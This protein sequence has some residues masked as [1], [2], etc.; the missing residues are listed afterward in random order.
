MLSGSFM[1]YQL[2]HAAELPDLDI[3][4]MS[5]PTRAN[6]QGVKGACQAR[7]IAA[8]QTIISA[9]QDAL[10]PLGVTHIDMPATSER[11]WRAI[12]QASARR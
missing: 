5:V 1:D 4:L 12:Q 2:P 7:A 6:R 11:V 3:T 9:V 10:V 8:P